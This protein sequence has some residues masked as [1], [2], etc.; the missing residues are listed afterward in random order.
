MKMKL[1]ISFLMEYQHIADPS[2]QETTYTALLCKNG[3]PTE[4]RQQMPTF[5][6]V[7][8]ENNCSFK[9]LKEI[10]DQL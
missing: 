2:S 7:N 1:N 10:S 4:T 8:T 6:L 3:L 5:P 9:L